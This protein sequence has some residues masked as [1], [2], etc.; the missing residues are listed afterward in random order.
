MEHRVVFI[1]NKAGHHDYVAA[2]HYGALRP[3]TSG[4]F[5]IFKT[6]RLREEIAV[7]LA[8][9]TIHDYLLLSGSSFIAGLCMSMWVLSHG[10]V[11][12]LLYDR[13]AKKYVVREFHG[14]AAKVELERMRDRLE[15]QRQSG[16]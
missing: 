14:N 4:N 9:S 8:H 3:I 1:S 2:E 16:N 5:A 12:L 15:Q 6:E 13:S 10:T 7:A 11:K